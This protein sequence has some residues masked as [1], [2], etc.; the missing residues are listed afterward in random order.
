MGITSWQELQ[1]A[2]ACKDLTPGTLTIAVPDN[3]TVKKENSPKKEAAANE[4]VPGPLKCFGHVKYALIFSHELDYPGVKSDSWTNIKR[5]TEI[6][7]GFIIEPGGTY[8]WFRDFGG[9]ICFP[10]TV[11]AVA[12]SYG[13]LFVEEKH[14][15]SNTDECAY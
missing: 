5:A 7:D 12:G 15:H 13:P 11:W 8:D 2:N 14:D 6:I 3:G 10:S 4:L 9:G 1:A